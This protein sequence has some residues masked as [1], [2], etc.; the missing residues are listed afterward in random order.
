MAI[1]GS[2]INWDFVTP[3][4]SDYEKSTS[5]TGGG[6]CKDTSSNDDPLLLF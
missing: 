5:A 1:L 3:S 2:V 6:R 4:V